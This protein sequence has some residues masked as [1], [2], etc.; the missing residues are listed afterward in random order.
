MFYRNIYLIKTLKIIS[1][2]LKITCIYFEIVSSFLKTN[3]I[4]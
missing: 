1:P 4:H 3:P 2:I